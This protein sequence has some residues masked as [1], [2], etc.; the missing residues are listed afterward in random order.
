MKPAS[1]RLQQLLLLTSLA[2]AYAIVG[3]LCLKLAWVHPS[4]SPIWIPTGIALAAFLIFGYRVWPAIAGAAFF[5]NITTAGS[6]GACLGIAV[7]N[8][9]EGL[10]GAW[11]VNHF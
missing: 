2:L 1:P 5:V 9:L 3:K 10:I 8:T 6:I 7:G 11:L 4:A